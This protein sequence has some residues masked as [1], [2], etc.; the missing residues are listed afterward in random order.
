[1][2]GKIKEATGLSPIPISTIEDASLAIRRVYPRLVEHAE[3]LK[4]SLIEGVLF[5]ADNQERRNL[6]VPK[7][8]EIATPLPV[9]SRFHDLVMLGASTSNDGRL[10]KAPFF[11]NHDERIDEI[12]FGA[13][14][15]N[16]G[17]PADYYVTDKYENIVF[18]R[19]LSNVS[20]PHLIISYAPVDMMEYH[21]ELQSVVDGI[22][23][24]D[25]AA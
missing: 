15:T 1:M 13:K 3:I 10:I 11:L 24:Y 18:N 14:F 7:T 20:A 12:I 25:L 8:T 5:V 17:T 23:R 22:Q 4:P 19:P 6:V 16:F 9:I 2:S 21:S